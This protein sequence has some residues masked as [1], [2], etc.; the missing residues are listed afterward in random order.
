M[1]SILIE[2]LHVVAARLCGVF[3]CCQIREADWSNRAELSQVR[4]GPI[5]QKHTNAARS[6]TSRRPWTQSPPPRVL[7]A[8]FV[9]GR[10]T[11][12]RAFYL[13]QVSHDEEIKRHMAL[14][15]PR[16]ECLPLT[17]SNGKNSLVLSGATHAHIYTQAHTDTYTNTHAGPPDSLKVI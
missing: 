4:V 16:L 14:N 5:F 9:F 12:R 7:S 11:I 17:K 8:G 3:F 2:K 10:S 13:F 1:W 15:V 6:L